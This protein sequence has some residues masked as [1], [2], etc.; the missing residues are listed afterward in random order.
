[1][2]RLQRLIWNGLLITAVSLVMRAVSVSF[3]VYISNKVGAVAMGLFTLI[4]TVYG[5]AVTLATSGIGLATT[6][7]VAEAMGE[8]N[9]S[10]RQALQTPTVRC[11]VHKCIRYALLFSVTTAVALLL[12]APWIGR[13]LLLDVR[14][15]L[16]LR[17]LALTLPPIALSSVFSGYFTAVRRMYKNAAVQILGQAVKI[18]GCIGLLSLLGARDVEGACL[19]IV[20]GGAVAE[21]VSFLA[22]Y[23]L[24][25][26]EKRSRVRHSRSACNAQVV[27]AKLLHIALPVAFSAY[28]RSGLV[29]WEHMLIPWGLERSGSGRDSSLAAYGMIH[30]MV[31]PLILLP[32][33]LTGSFAGLLVP[34]TAEAQAQ[35]NTARMDRM[36]EAVF[37]A[38]L[39]FA[40][41][42]AGILMCFSYDLSAVIYPQTNAGAYILM[43]APLIPLMYLDTSV[44]AL[45]KGMGEQFYCMIVNIADSLLSVILVWLLLPRLGIL[46]YILTVYFTEILNDA[47]SILRLLQ[48]RR[49]KFR[50]VRRVVLPLVGIVLST[51]AVRHLLSYAD[52][53]VQSVGSLTLQIVLTALLYALFLLIFRKPRRNKE[54]STRR[55]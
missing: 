46:G 50:L 16:P 55:P 1:M 12:A 30:S 23:V 5:F 36:T 31:F 41:G 49:I 35:G 54:K 24:Y 27:Q 22:Q 25:M 15:V 51:A 8:E 37:E 11:I 32:S 42:T 21:V 47:L 13:H 2:K 7:M 9:T 26:L 29:T 33:A 48:L 10:A 34:E 28:V 44:D 20:L 43:L 38:V 3:N 53:A 14:T 19:A 40:V 45:L 4:S 18:Y 39:S 17:V 52:I 6:K